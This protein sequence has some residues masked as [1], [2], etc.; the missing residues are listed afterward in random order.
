MHVLVAYA[1]KHGST[2]GI[3]ERIAARLC[4]HGLDAEA[5]PVQSVRDP[6][7]YDAVVVGAASYLFHWMKEARS[8]VQRHRA[9]L[10][11]RPVWTFSSGPVGTDEVDAQGQDVRAVCLPRE[12]PTIDREIGSRGHRV[13]FGAIGPEFRPKGLAE[14][15]V[16]MMP[17]ARDSFPK[18]DFRDWDDVDAWADGIARELTT[19]ASRS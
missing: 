18:G 11:A 17:A 1:T 16:W 15:L 8:F 12:M 2:A 10:A 13:F 4:R 14:R 6:A 7:D 3:A 5:R 9:A 19:G